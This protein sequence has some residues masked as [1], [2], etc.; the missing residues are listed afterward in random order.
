MC[1]NAMPCHERSQSLQERS[2]YPPCALLSERSQS[3]QEVASEH[4]KARDALKEELEKA[5]EQIRV[6]EKRMEVPL[7][8]ANMNAWSP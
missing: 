7:R 1:I 2:I 5:Q 6:L 8:T 4:R 3:L